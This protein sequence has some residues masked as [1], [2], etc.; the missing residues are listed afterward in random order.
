[1]HG[2]TSHEVI[3]TIREAGPVRDQGLPRQ[4]GDEVRAGIVAHLPERR[5]RQPELGRDRAARRRSSCSGSSPSPRASACST[6]RRAS[7]ACRRPRGIAGRLEAWLAQARGHAG[8]ALPAADGAVG[9]EEV[10]LRRRQVRA[11]AGGFDH[12]RPLPCAGPHAGAQRTD[13]ARVPAVGD[14]RRL[15]TRRASSRSTRSRAAPPPCATSSSRSRANRILNQGDT[16]ALGVPIF[17]PYLEMAHLE[18]YDLHL[19]PRSTRSRR[20]SSSIRMRSSRSSSIRRS[21]RSSS[22][23]RA[24]PTRWRCRR[25]HHQEDR[26]RPQE[27]A[28]SD[29][30]DRRRLW[31]VRAGLPVADGRVPEEHHRRLLATASTSAAPAGASGR[32]PSTRTTSSTR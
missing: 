19:R 17:T 24:I 13:R 12:R 16:I 32:S 29:P 4:G 28:G 22:S 3:P 9:G 25:A 30:A 8:R 11:R 2:H 15:R 21:R 20:T 1:M 7:A 23:T 14:V 10:R 27:A 26:R 5:P 18:D 6:C 31:H